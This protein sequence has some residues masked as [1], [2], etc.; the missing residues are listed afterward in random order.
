MKVL[1]LCSGKPSNPQWSFEVTRSYVYE[2]IESIKKLGVEYDTYFIEG[3]GIKGY[4]K[5][6]KVMKKKIQEYQPDFIHAHY[7]LS[8]LLA[9]FQRKIPVITT[10][11]GSDIHLK[12]NVKFSKLSSLLSK[13]NIFV[14][15]DLSAKINYKHAIHMIPCGVD[16]Q[17]FYPIEKDK[18]RE[19]LGLNKDVIYGLFTSSF[20]NTVKNYP[21]AN[22]SIKLSKYDIS[23]IEL[24]G[25]KREEV[26]L[27]MNAVDFLLVTS[28]SETGPIVVK[29]AMCCNT[30]IVTVDVGDVNDVIAQT[31]NCYVTSYN[32]HELARSIDKLLESNSKTDG[33]NTIEKY[34]LKNIANQIFEIYKKVVK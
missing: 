8:G 17:R 1:I 19:K 3:K 20:S 30:P 27:L 14:H 31:A 22:E 11:H 32:S 5:N 26:N 33:R 7:G 4:I 10:Y 25:Y 2:Q 18:A 28:F 9:N 21:L 16:T 24:K 29:E 34:S 6:Y 23:L 12:S 15:K 13:E